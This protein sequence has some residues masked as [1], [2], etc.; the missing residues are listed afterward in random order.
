MTRGLYPPDSLSQED[1]QTLKTVRRDIYTNAM[2]GGGV[3]GSAGLVLH[4]GAQWARRF[5]LTNA[6]L[7]RNTLMLSVMGGAAFGMFVFA[8]ATGKEEVHFLHPIFQVGA[9]TPGELDFRDYRKRMM[10]A[11][12]KE[13][14]VDRM[15]ETRLTRRKSMLEGFQ[16]G[17]GLNDSHGGHWYK[18]NQK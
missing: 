13:E 16:K 18:E 12:Q 9:M 6:T 7:N 1:I 17:H 15:L 2:L 5:G 8:Q 4:T 3:G 11:G 10:E 14:D